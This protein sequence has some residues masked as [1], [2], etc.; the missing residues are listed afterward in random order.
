LRTPKKVAH[1]HLWEQPVDISTMECHEPPCIRHLWSDELEAMRTVRGTPPAFPLQSH[2]VER[3]MKL[4]SE[5]SKKSYIWHLR[6]KY[7][8]ATNKS[9]KEHLSLDLKLILSELLSVISAFC[10]IS[11]N[12]L[13]K[14]LN[15]TIFFYC[16][17]FVYFQ[18]WDKSDILLF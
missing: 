4:T 16:W 7:I 10:F 11:G 3:A 6:N 1:A 15:F 18:R 12:N 17:M 2:R 13:K 5:A 14:Y 9:R 8:V